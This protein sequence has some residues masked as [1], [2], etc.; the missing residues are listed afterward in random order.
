MVGWWQVNLEA[1]SE[2]NCGHVVFTTAPFEFHCLRMQLIVHQMRRV[3]KNHGLRRHFLEQIGMPSQGFKLKIF[4]D[5]EVFSSRLTACISTGRIHET[6]VVH[7][8]LYSE[9]NC[10]AESN[11]TFRASTRVKSQKQ[12]RLE[13]YTLILMFDLNKQAHH[14]KLRSQ[15]SWRRSSRHD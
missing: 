4:I 6:K 5:I 14:Q 1:I 8:I 10:F 15:P 11:L 7:F 2:S 13:N 9:S 12:L 3:E